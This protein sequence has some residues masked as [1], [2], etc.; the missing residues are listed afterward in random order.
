M[1]LKELIRR[2]RTQSNDKVKPYLW[3]DEELKD[4]FNDAQEQA[5]IRGR[6]LRDDVTGAVA[7][8]ALDP[9]QHTYPLHESVYEIISITL[10]GRSGLR[11][12]TLKSREWLDE[13][14][15]EWRDEQER[16]AVW[17]IQDETSLRI[18][19][20][21]EEGDALHIDVYRLPL[22]LL[23][24]DTDEPEIHK[25]SHVHL[26]DWVLHQA[27]S[28]PDSE[29]IDP[30]RSALAEQKFIR[31]FGELPDSDMRRITREDVPHHNRAILP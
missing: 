30:Q 28:V 19:G 12:I 22:E 1:N 11:A 3:S 10:R 5:C 25:A 13:Y 14:S 23:S 27:F 15:R 29:T 26:I 6:L 24:H 9:A 21:I 2:F 4:W 20:R 16:P 17:A 7:H 18:V 8:I 31:Y